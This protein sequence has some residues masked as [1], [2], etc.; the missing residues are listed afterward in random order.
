[1][2]VCLNETDGTVVSLVDKVTIFDNDDRLA[3]GAVFPVELEI[4]CDVLDWARDPG[5]N[6]TAH[7]RL[8]FSIE[9]QNGRTVFNVDENALA[10]HS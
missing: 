8:H 3:S 5:G 9:D 4:P 10:P 7:I 1:M 6:L 2:E